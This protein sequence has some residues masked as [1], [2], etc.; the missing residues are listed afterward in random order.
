MK[1]YTFL[2]LVLIMATLISCNQF[3]AKHPQANLSD[4]NKTTDLTSKSILAF[5]DYI[6]KNLDR[7]PKTQSLYAWRFI[8]LCRTIWH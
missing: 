1:T 3:K 2:R 4:E 7:Y 6:D 8:V 5:K